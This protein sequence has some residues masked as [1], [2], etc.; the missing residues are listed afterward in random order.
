MSQIVS[1]NI[2]RE[3][4]KKL[5]RNEGDSEQQT[6]FI[7]RFSLPRY[8]GMDRVSKRFAGRYVY[9]AQTRESSNL[10]CVS[11]REIFIIGAIK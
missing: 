2:Y 5:N 8:S 6:L 10:L 4:G 11:D 3:I 9:S 7:A 1:L